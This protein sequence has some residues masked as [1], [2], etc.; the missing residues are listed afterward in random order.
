MNERQEL[1]V[2]N[3]ELQARIDAA[4]AAYEKRRDE[5]KGF[6]NYTATEMYDAL[7]SSNQRAKK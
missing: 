5:V 1:V 2:L 7:K 4:I 6:K 3:L